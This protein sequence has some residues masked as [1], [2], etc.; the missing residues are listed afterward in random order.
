MARRV[1]APADTEPAQPHTPVRIRAL[2][3]TLQPSLRRVAE[4]VLADPARAAT[5]TVTELAAAC[6]T[7][8]TTVIRF[9]K[10]LGL[11]GYPQLRLAGTRG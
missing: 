6:D 10:A 11:P 4:Q 1:A 5:L 3:P 7:S 8:E 9:W 2:L